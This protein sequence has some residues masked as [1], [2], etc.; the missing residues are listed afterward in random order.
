M[1][2]SS[3]A[4]VLPIACNSFGYCHRNEA[5]EIPLHDQRPAVYLFDDMV[6]ELAGR[7][8]GTRPESDAA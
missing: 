4:G 2:I 1:T 6:K 8:E 7:D 3:H 5:P